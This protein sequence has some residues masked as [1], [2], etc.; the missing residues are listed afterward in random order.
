[1]A[2]LPEFALRQIERWCA[3]RV[4]A[5]LRDQVRVECR[6]RGRSVTIVERRSPEAGTEW[7]EQKIAQLR[8]DEFGIWS[9]RRPDRNGRWLTYPDAPVAS[10][11]PA[12]LAEI[13][14]NPD[15]IF[16]G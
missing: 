13:D 16:W 2:A 1:M 6:T 8:L 4:P 12:L 3:Q 9:V 5:R 7:T 10:S 14:R 11:P 15:G